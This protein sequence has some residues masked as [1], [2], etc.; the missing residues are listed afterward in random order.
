MS[1]YFPSRHSC[2]E[3]TNEKNNPT[4][5]SSCLLSPLLQLVARWLEEAYLE[6][7][8]YYEEPVQWTHTL[9]ALL[10]RHPPARTPAAAAAT[11]ASVSAAFFE[12]AGATASALEREHTFLVDPDGPLRR[13]DALLAEDEVDG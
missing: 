4:G 2:V 11:V 1:A 3:R 12:P 8:Q 7:V 13:P 6:N 9:R 10:A 5:G